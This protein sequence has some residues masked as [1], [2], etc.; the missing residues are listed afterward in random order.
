[1]YG[2]GM[3]TVEKVSFW[4]LYKHTVFVASKMDVPPGQIGG[5]K[6]TSLQ[7]AIKC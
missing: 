1:M 4:L 5:G 7:K 3:A 6:L 2:D